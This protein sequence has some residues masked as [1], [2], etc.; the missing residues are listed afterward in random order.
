[1]IMPIDFEGRIYV[2]EDEQGKIIGAGTRKAC[3]VLLTLITKKL[4]IPVQKPEP[5]T[6]FSDAN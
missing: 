6:P 3:A 5:P 1:M 4:A 2:L